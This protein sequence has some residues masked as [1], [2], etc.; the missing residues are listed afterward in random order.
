MKTD[1]SSLP[2]A[3]GVY[4]FK[5]KG[6]K[7]LYVG[8][9]INI[10]SRVRSHIQNRKDPKEQRICSNTETVDYIGTRSELEALILEDT[11]IK[12]YKPKFNIRLKDDKSYPYLLI[13]SE[14][15]P[16]IRQVRGL[17]PDAG[18]FFGP[19]GDPRAVR[20]SIRWLRK[21]FPVR[22]CRRDMDRTSRPCLEHH[23]GR[24]IAPCSGKI[25]VE[26]YDVMVQGLRGFLAGRREGV[27][28]DLKNEMWKA[29]T[30]EHYEKAALIR[31]LLLGLERIGEG[32]RVILLKVKDIDIVK[33]DEKELA[34]VVIKVREGR[35]IDAVSFSLEGE[36]SL[37][38]MDL[39]FISSYYSLSAH[40]PR[41]II[42]NRMNMNRKSKEE[43]EIFLSAKRKGE[44]LIRG[45]RGEDERS[46]VEMADRNIRLFIQKREREL[47]TDDSMDQLKEAL[48][49]TNTPEVI[50]GFDISHLH[51]TGTVASMV[52]FR[53]GRPIR[54]N[55]RKFK[56]RT[57]G[58]DDLRSIKEV[59][60]RRYRRLLDQDDPFP[61]LILIDGGRGQLS[62]AL[63][64]IEELELN[65][66]P[67]LASLAKKE[68]EIYLKGKRFP[69]VLKKS[70]PALRLLQR[71]RDEAHRFA[72]AYQ[73]KLRGKEL[74][75]LKK[76]D[77][78]G[79][80]RARELMIAFDS[81]EEMREGGAGGIIKRS[82]VPLNVACRVIE[83][84]ERENNRATV[85]LD[86]EKV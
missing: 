24:C 50:E 79:D 45:P 1:P 25:M 47:Q 8:K 66:M 74:F 7:V 60:G 4:L 56:I 77:G 37:L 33:I 6:G 49:M 82:S 31:D 26:D 32:Q 14:R 58:N 3:C 48:G 2:A 11:L 23:L 17:K 63:E 54:S 43:L 29:S 15:Y 64:A 10:R 27:V 9:A 55:Y 30:E 34:A 38:G 81:L 59:V 35:V 62:A 78:I 19:H 68:E 69:L 21:I 39:D 75:L 44:V 65:D 83:F 22:S 46:M 41:R 80:K 13:T 71:V 28:E 40:V 51:G 12:R 86:L 57:A 42:A 85:H 52:H 73:R 20:R 36:G 5:G 76:V 18:E 70:D 72:V 61:D 84:L 53:K 67:F 16:A